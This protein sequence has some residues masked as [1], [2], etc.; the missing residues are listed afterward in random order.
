[1]PANSADGENGNAGLVWYLPAI[2]SV[3]KKFSAAAA[4]ADHG[5]A[6]RGRR[7]GD[8]GQF[9]VVGR[10]VTGAEQGFHGVRMMEG[11]RTLFSIVA[12]QGGMPSLW[13]RPG[14]VAINFSRL[15]SPVAAGCRLH[16]ADIRR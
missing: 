10:A 8:I 14:P 5:F 4:I 7:I 1:M 6:G 15:I 12:W 9:E 2:I 16:I 3:S 11:G 13:D